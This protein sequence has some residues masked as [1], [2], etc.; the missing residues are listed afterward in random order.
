MQRLARERE[1]RLA[2]R[3]AL[4]R[5]RVQE[6]RDV[7]R[8]SFPPDGQLPLRDELADAVADEMHAQNRSV[9]ETDDLDDAGRAED[10]ALAVAGEVVLVGDDRVGTVRCR[11]LRLG[12][13]DRCDLGLRVRDLRDVR[14]G[15]GDG[16][17][18]GDLLGDEDALLEAA[19]R[20]LGPRDDVADRPDVRDRRCA[21]GRRSRRS[22]DPA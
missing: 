21:A 12:E 7:F 13:S 22:R 3:F 9:L 18:P 2:E 14:V 5:V 15:D 1:E 8:M 19:M 4:R 16:R 10:L 20:E 17:Q 6:R 11:G